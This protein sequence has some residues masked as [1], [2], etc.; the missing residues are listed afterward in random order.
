MERTYQNLMYILA[1]PV[2]EFLIFERG[3]PAFA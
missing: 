2:K 3:M 1:H